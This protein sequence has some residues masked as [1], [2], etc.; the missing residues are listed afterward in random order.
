MVFED[1]SEQAVTGLLVHSTLHQRSEL[2]LGFGGPELVSN[3]MSYEGVLTDNMYSST[4]PGLFAAGD[5]TGA[6]PSLAG[7]ISAGATVGAAV[8]GKLF[9]DHSS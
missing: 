9:I 5:V 7:A 8:V 1:G 2:V 3:A 4:I 6:M